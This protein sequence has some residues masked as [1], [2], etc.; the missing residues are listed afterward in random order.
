MV[1]TLT[2]LDTQDIYK[3]DAS[4]DLPLGLIPLTVDHKRNHKYSKSIHTPIVN[5]TYNKVSIPRATVMSTLNQL[6]S[7]ALKS[8]IY[9]EPQQKNHRTA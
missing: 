1:Q 7:K 8:A 4:H 2:V 5:T 3:L 6:K 9:H